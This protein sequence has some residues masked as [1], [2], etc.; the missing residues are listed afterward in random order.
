[1]RERE[2]ESLREREGGREGEKEEDRE[3]GNV[4]LGTK[5]NMEESIERVKGTV[6]ENIREEERESGSDRHSSGDNW[7][8]K[9]F[10]HHAYVP[11][12]V[13]S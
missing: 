2:R 5:R 12:A 7:S 11:D 10:M 4:E 8:L 1:M 3:R 13:H 6:G 9:T